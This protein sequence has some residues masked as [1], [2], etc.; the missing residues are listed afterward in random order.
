MV[1]TTNS[2]LRKWTWK[3]NF[4]ITVSHRSACIIAFVLHFWMYTHN[5]CEFYIHF[6]VLEF[7][8]CQVSGNRNEIRKRNLQCV[9]WNGLELLDRPP[10]LAMWILDPCKMQLC[11]PGCRSKVGMPIFI[12]MLWKISWSKN[13]IDFDIKAAWREVKD[14]QFR[15]ITY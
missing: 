4:E 10:Q 11:R 3:L 2:S 5:L 9:L 14:L 6:R 1:F 8:C 15:R 12:L 7:H 13:H